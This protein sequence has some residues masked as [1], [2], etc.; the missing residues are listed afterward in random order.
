MQIIHSVGGN[1]YSSYYYYFHVKDRSERQWSRPWWGSPSSSAQA[2]GCCEEQW[3]HVLRPA[4]DPSVLL[5]QAASSLIRGPGSSCLGWGRVAAGI[6][7]SVGRK[8]LAHL[9]LYKIN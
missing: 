2:V 1:Y 9:T 5:Q 3:G 4:L 6:L 8:L 7:A